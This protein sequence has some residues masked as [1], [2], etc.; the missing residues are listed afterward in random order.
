M[1]RRRLSSQSSWVKVAIMMHSRFGTLAGARRTWLAV[2]AFVGL[3]AVASASDWYVDQSYSNCSQSDGSVGKPYCTVGA[4]LA[5][6]QSG[7]TIHVASGSYPEQLNLSI[8][9]TLIGTSGAAATILQASQTIVTVSGANVSL[10]GFTIQNAT[11][12]GIA[13]SNGAT[14]SMTDCIVKGNVSKFDE[15]SGLRSTQ[16]SIVTVQRTTFQSNVTKYV[17]GGCILAE[18]GNCTI[19]D[20][21]FDGNVGYVGGAIHATNGVVLTI[22]STTF[23]NHSIGGDGGAI[24]L[25]DSATAAT[26][27]NCTFV[28]N[29]VGI[30]GGAIYVGSVASLDVKDSTFDSNAGNYGGAVSTH[31]AASF[32]RCTFHGNEATASSD[33][34]IGGHGGAVFSSYSSSNVISFTDCVFDSN[35]ADAAPVE[36]SGAGALS[37]EMGPSSLARCR[38]TGNVSNGARNRG[39][40]AIFVGDTLTATDCEITG[41]R[42]DS[43]L[44]WIAG[45]GAILANG[46]ASI[47]VMLQRCTVAGNT[48][49]W[50]G[51]GLLVPPG[52][53]IYLG[54]TI[55]AGNTATGT[56]GAPDV[57]GFVTSQDWNDFGNS[58]GMKK[59]L[60]THDLTDV[61]PLFV[62]PT[63]GDFSLQPTSPCV[64]SGDPTATPSGPDVGGNPRL[65]DGNLDRVLVLDRGA[66]EFNNVH[67]DVTGTPTPGGTLTL[68]TSGTSG[69][70]LLMI[71]GVAPG[72][73][74]IH[75]FGA[76]FI[77]LT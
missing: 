29:Q 32:E 20:C 52:G 1:N 2:G 74:F 9:L 59:L 33:G 65:L 76:L 11:D 75:P 47:Q 54:H 24:S 46:S 64:D 27:E 21:T 38:F 66:R 8:D 63:N 34:H 17:Y 60:G 28:N 25:E 42:A 6:S 37:L 49:S 50:T 26:I 22:E 77:D 56:G 72:E 30:E 10:S 57:D 55:V 71:A 31:S 41:N 23:K 7:D 45:P 14:L 68:T 40:G 39:G 3:A 73:L 13:A 4:A 48:T 44:S 36:G 58:T 15:G 5:V 43:A 16:S 53:T 18:G 62:D 61:D 12:S 69:L 19:V 51:G 70:T 35:Q 67:L